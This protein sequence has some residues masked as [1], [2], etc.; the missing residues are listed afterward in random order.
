[1]QVEELTAGM[2]HAADFGDA[3]VEAGLVTREVITDQL[4]VPGAQEVAR[5]FA[6][7]AGAEVVDH[8]LEG[9]VRR[10]AISPDISSMRFLLSG[11]Q[12]LHRRF[13]GMHDSLSQ[14]RFAQCIHQRL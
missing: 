6:G 4:A 8:R 5:M 1:M 9:R 14:H 12:H 10:R 7:A 13:I 3:Q 2:R 11:R